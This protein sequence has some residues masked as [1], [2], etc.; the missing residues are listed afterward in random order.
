MN[1]PRIFKD[2]HTLQSL[3][4][5]RQNGFTLHSLAFIFN[6]DYSSIYHHVKGIKSKDEKTLYLSKLIEIIEPDY[7]SVLSML[8]IN[9]KQLKTYADYL[10]ED[11][12]RNKFPNS[13]LILGRV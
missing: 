11:R 4:K 8:E 10:R 12:E 6:A 3:V 5:L 9:T 13:R 7:S 2:K 1:R